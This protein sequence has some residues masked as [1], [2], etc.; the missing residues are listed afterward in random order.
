MPD[1]YIGGKRGNSLNGFYIESTTIA[2]ILEKYIP[3]VAQGCLPANSFADFF[4]IKLLIQLYINAVDLE[5]CIFLWEKFMEEGSNALVRGVVSLVSISENSVRNGEHPLTILENL[6]EN[7]IKPQL[8]EEYERLKIEITDN[9]VESLRTLAREFRAQ[10]WHKCEKF[11]IRKLEKCSSFK[12]EEIISLRDIFTDLIN[13]KNSSTKDRLKRSVKLPGDLQKSF[14]KNKFEAGISKDQF[15]E[16]IS[17]INPRLQE[18]AS[19]IFDKFDEDKSGL[20]DFRELTICI[21]IMCKGDFDEK[22]KICFDAYDED[23]SGYIQPNEMEALIENL[24]KPYKQNNSESLS[25]ENLDVN[26]IKNSMRIICEKSGGVL[27]FK[28]FLLAVKADSALYSCFCNHFTIVGTNG[29]ETIRTTTI[30][31]KKS[32]SLEYKVCNC[33][34]I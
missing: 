6:T 31:R 3:A 16:M 7:Q 22:L 10:E 13:K 23:K 15:I 1:F 2:G 34:I 32:H 26:I 5:S 27:C 19:L 4:S 18:S 21:S 30:K 12:E 29:I 33:L 11:S 20:L 9:R 28:D 17:D 25:E 8:A 24:I 14:A